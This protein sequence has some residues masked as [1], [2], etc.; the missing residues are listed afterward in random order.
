MNNTVIFILLVLV[1]IVVGALLVIV[2]NNVRGN[3]LNK[4]SEKILED[5][6]KQADKLKRDSILET[7]EEL[8]RLKL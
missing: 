6:R 4:K 1:G 7:K 8:H 3:S 5:T 2:L